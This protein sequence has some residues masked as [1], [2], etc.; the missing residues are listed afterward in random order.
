MTSLLKEHNKNLLDQL[1]H[2]EI[3]GNFFNELFEMTFSQCLEHIQGK[4]YYQIL[5]G[6][7]SLEKI[8]EKFCDKKEINDKIFCENFYLVFMNYQD[9]IE[10]KTTRKPRNSK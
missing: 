3:G 10:K 2:S 9:L 5:N 8:M 1:I 6:I 7:M 4:K